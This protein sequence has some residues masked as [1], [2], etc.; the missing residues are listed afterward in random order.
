MVRFMSLSSGSSGNCYY[1]ESPEGAILIDAGI[2]IRNI[3]HDLKSHGITI[4]DHVKAILLTHDH[5][6]HIRA[7]GHISKKYLLPIYATEKVFRGIDMAR[8]VTDK[9]ENYLR[10]I[11]EPEKSFSIVGF[12]VTPFDIPHDA[13]QNVGY[14]IV[15]HGLSFTL[16]TDVGHITPKITEFASRAKHLVVEANYDREMLKYGTYPEFLKQRV[17]GPTGHLSNQ[18]TAEFLASIFNPD[19]E[20]IWLCHLSKD[21]NHPELCWKTIENRLFNEGIRVGKDVTLTTLKRTQA[22]PLYVLVP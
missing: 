6:D 17:S 19:M 5:A 13:S 16:M 8:Y 3:Q 9:P 4:S 18:E 12:D 7:I 15:G 10:H 22:S 2:N 14:H 1:V 20:N 11:I 21:N